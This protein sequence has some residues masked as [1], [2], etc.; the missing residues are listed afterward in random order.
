MKKILFIENRQRT[1]VWQWMADFL[2]E[3]G[4][5]VYW[6]VE[7]H[8]F[9]PRGKNVYVIPYPTKKDIQIA[10]V[11]GMPQQL[12]DYV[13]YVD[14]NIYCFK[15]KS[16][17]YIYY[18]YNAIRDIIL[19]IR[20]DITI[21]EST[22]VHELLSIFICKQEGF[23][24]LHPSSCRYPVDNFSFYLYNTLE[25][26]MGSGESLSYEEALLIANNIANRIIQ[27]SYMSKNT[28]SWKKYFEIQYN[29]LLFTYCYF[30]GE[31]YCTPSP[32]RKIQ[33]NAQRKKLLKKWEL[34]TSE[35]PWEMEI[36]EKFVVMYPM[37]MQPEANLDVWGY[38]Y[39]NQAD[40]IKRIADQLKD[41]EILLVKPN[42]KVKYEL[43]EELLSLLTSYDNIS[44][45]PISTSMTEVFPKT[46]IV[47]AVTG[48]ITIECI[49]SNKPV[50]TLINT[51]NNKQRNCLYLDDLM[52]F[53]QCIEKVK[54]GNFETI[55]DKERTDFIQELAAK[56]YKGSP[57]T[58]YR[59]KGAQKAL[60]DILK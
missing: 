33:L 56:S 50:V 23:L 42:P 13:T 25:P 5:E 38:P 26:F 8:Y 32:W 59:N 55:T 35:R 29:K 41:D 44:I 46:N 10:K 48:T 11:K 2:E 4:C 3:N 31:R 34:L 22:L 58:Y 14:R 45:I 15:C 43:T 28:F 54:S 12:F 30:R 7:N 19:S 20:P 9:K 21:G 39:R 49:V 47:V 24:F 36:K 17:D 27:P 16:T 60:L 53:R 18:Y 52:K 37:Q 57:Y 1:W 51:L 40:T 6:I